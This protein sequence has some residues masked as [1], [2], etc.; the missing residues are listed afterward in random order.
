MPT[1]EM[2][3]SMPQDITGEKSLI[4]GAIPLMHREREAVGLVF[5]TWIQ[6]K[7]DEI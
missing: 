1:I 5:Q 6:M 2:N 7:K 3:K 4:L